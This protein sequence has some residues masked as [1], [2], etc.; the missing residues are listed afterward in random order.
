VGSEVVLILELIERGADGPDV[1]AADG[2]A[3]DVEHVGVLLCRLLVSLLQLAQL[4]GLEVK[5]FELVVLHPGPPSVLPG[6]YLSRRHLQGEVHA[7]M[8]SGDASVGEVGAQN[9]LST[10][11][12]THDE[13]HLALP[14][15]TAQRLVEASDAG[16][17]DPELVGVFL[18]I[19][20]SGLSLAKLLTPSNVRP[21][22]LHGDT[23]GDARQRLVRGVEVILGQR[24]RSALHGQL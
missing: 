23:P 2:H 17:D 6:G 12:G 4:T 13:S 14:A 1:G 20:A 7:A 8:P 19:L 18:L 5:P 10:A 3:Q 15:A 21:S 22:T 9:R 16:G 24:L 11:R